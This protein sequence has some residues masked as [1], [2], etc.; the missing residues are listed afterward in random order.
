MSIKIGFDGHCVIKDNIITGPV[1][2]E[3][4]HLSHEFI[5]NFVF[6]PAMPPDELVIA[7]AKYRRVET[8]GITGITIVNSTISKT[9]RAESHQTSFRP[10]DESSHSDDRE[11]QKG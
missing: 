1:E 11:S 9:R 8:S 6:N 10:D 3:H 5:N 2:I 7:G 4:S